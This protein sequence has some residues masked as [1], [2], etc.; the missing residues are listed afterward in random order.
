MDNFKRLIA[1]IL[2]VAFA[3]FALAGTVEV[4]PM[5]AG[6]ASR[7]NHTLSY[8]VTYAASG[9]GFES[10]AGYQNTVNGRTSFYQ[11]AV[12]FTKADLG[13]AG[14]GLLKNV[15][16][17]AAFYAVIL[18]IGYSLD[19]ITGDIYAD[20]GKPG[21]VAVA[22]VSYSLSSGSCGASTP[23]GTLQCWKNLQPAQEGYPASE[24]QRTKP[25]A[26]VLRADGNVNYYKYD[27]YNPLCACYVE[28]GLQI[29]AVGNI[30][31]QLNYNIGDELATAPTVATDLQVG[32]AAINAPHTWPEYMNTPGTNAVPL[33]PPVVAKIP[34]VRAQWY[35]DNNITPAPVTPEP[36]VAD[37]VAVSISAPDATPVPLFCTWASTLCAWLNWTKEEPSLPPVVDA[38]LPVAPIVQQSYISGF[39]GG[40]CPAPV[41]VSFS[42][43]G[44]SY[45]FDISY[46]PACTFANMIWYVNIAAASILAAFILAGL[47]SA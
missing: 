16:I 29:Y 18:G 34:E 21:V 37:P 38:P 42:Y 35:A 47:R 3:P 15:G 45:G 25:R 2:M 40:V 8:P 31:P 30:A 46:G 7:I 33:H 41:P 28:N 39:G 20:A 9:A 12:T 19:S 17:Q 11:K 32:E 6:Q 43:K 24:W 23:S 22:N 27:T 44:D 5:A 10:P 13:K 14:K 1:A 4:V 36:V 26:R